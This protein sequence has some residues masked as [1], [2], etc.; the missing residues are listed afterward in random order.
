[1]TLQQIINQTTKSIT[2][3]AVLL[4]GAS[5]IS[6]LLGLVRDRLLTYHFGAGPILDSYYAAF[7]IPDFLYNLLV[8]G[9]L[10]AAFIPMFSEFLHKEESRAWDFLNRT[11]STLGALFLGVSL[12]CLIFTPWLINVI[13]P[14]FEGAKLEQ[15]ILFTRIMLLSPLFMGFSAFVGGALQSLKKFFIYALAPILYNAGIIFGILVLVPFIGTIGLAIGVVLGAALHLLIQYPALR[16]SGF[17]PRW[18]WGWNHPDI[19][20]LLF[21][22]G[23]R[24]IALAATQIN[25]VILTVFASTMGDGAVAVFNLAN[26]IQYLPIGLIAV[27]FAVAAFPVMTEYAAQENPDGL[28]RTIGSTIRMILTTIIPVTI[29]FIVLRAQF[30]RLILGSGEF[31]WDATITTADVLG[32][33]A[34]GLLGQSLVHVLARAFYAVKDTRTPALCGLSSVAIGVVTAYIVKDSL[35]ISGLALA[36]AVQETINAGLLWILLQRHIGAHENQAILKT[37]YKLSVAGLVL[38]VVAQSL[39]LPIATFVDT[40]TFWGIFLQAL[41]V[42]VGGLIAYITVGLLLRVEEV[43]TILQSIHIKIKRVGALL[44]IDTTDANAP[45]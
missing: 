7:R 30:V 18:L 41:G 21:L 1:M 11:L 17:A 36:V 40:K 39:K 34:I 12:L 33:F 6:R 4:G 19:K 25:L 37:L 8:L 24:I 15:T 3:A 20:R 22:M 35:G 26:N 45:R 16:A 9:I 44:P 38:L 23:P 31:N 43:Y 2:T 42:S 28:A 5:L 29:L 13:A 14:G 32:F 10:S 27:S